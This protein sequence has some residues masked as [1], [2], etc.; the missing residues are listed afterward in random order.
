[1]TKIS[2]EVIWMPDRSRSSRRYSP[3]TLLRA[4]H[5]AQHVG[6]DEPADEQIGVAEAVEP[7]QRPHPVVGVAGERHDL[8]GGR[9]LD[10]V[11]RQ[12]SISMPW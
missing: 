4:L 5:E 9:L 11:E 10:G 7:D 3:T 6:I 12:R 1:M 8:A 2:A